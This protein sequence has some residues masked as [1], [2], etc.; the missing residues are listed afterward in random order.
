MT[1]FEGLKD[2]LRVYIPGQYPRKILEEKRERAEFKK[3]YILEP[4]KWLRQLSL[5]AFAVTLALTIFAYFAPQFVK[6]SIPASTISNPIPQQY[7][8]FVYALLAYLTMPGII[9]NLFVSMALSGKISARKEAIDMNLHA[10]YVVLLGFAKA[11]LHPNDIVREVATLNLGEISREFARA[12]YAMRYSGKTLR[13]AML[14]VAST[15]PSEKLA[16]LLRGIVGVLEAGGNLARYVEDALRATEVERKVL[17]SEYLKKLDLAA[18]LYLTISLAIPVM[19]I[20]MSVAKS[21]AG[22]GDIASTYGLIYGFMPIS[23]AIL[24][25]ILHASSPEKGVERPGINYLTI[26]PLSLVAGLAIGLVTPVNPEFSAVAAVTFGS[27]ITA[28][29]LRKKIKDDEKLSTQIPQYFNRVISLVEAGKDVSVAFR[30]AASEQDEPLRRYVRTFAEML[31]KGI[32]RDKA[33]GWLFNATPS[34]DLKLASRVLSKT[35]NV[36]GRLIEVL[37]ALSSE[38]AR[39]N[40]FRKERYSSAKMYGGI[41]LMAAFMFFGIAAALSTML[42]GE[43]EKISEA[44]T[45]S[46]SVGAA[47]FAVSPV[48]IDRARTVLR[49]ACYIVGAG[50]AV[51][52]AA[53]RGDFRRLAASLSIVLASAFAVSALFLQ[54]GPMSPI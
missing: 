22:Q 13:A 2:A 1:T 36:S 31:D 40:A 23:S 30:V 33:F 39:I 49:H 9:F 41:M 11:K 26:V 42:L 45:V 5:V 8:P 14:D 44:H 35:V 46:S 3:A 20:S 43:F 53:T 28:L 12:Y 29:L 47:R 52:V 10:L 7:R 17:F 32:S 38:L 18:E 50:A 4:Q 21:V 15:T 6:F 54:L 24:V 34:S 25:L 16:E 37:L 51:G 27:I 19:V 48:V